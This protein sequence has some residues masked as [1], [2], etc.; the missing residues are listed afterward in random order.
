M[1]IQD[2]LKRIPNNTGAGYFTVPLKSLDK[3]LR[4]KH[5][6]VNDQKIISKLSID[7]NTGTFAS[8]ADLAKISIAEVNSLE[9]IELDNIDVRD[10]FILC[11]AIR[12][13]NYMDD[14]IIKFKCKQCEHEF[15]K[16]LDFSKM[17]ALAT[18]FE[19]KL[20]EAEIKTS[21]GDMKVT[22]GIPKQLD[23]IMLEM[24]YNRVAKTRDVTTAEKYIDYIIVCM[25]QAYF[26]ND[27]DQWEEVEDFIKMEYLDK[28]EFMQNIKANIEDI[29]KLFAEIGM[30]TNEFFYDIDCPKCKEKNKPFL[31]TSDFF[32]L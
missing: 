2:I 4:I 20:K 25:K 28:V 11:C 8:E 29:S 1:N 12:K 15:D 13:E 3:E 14:F 18:D 31:D 5:L 23:L 26:K 21:L 19:I 17:I 32:T 16:D 27:T 24:Y 30:I 22:I 10:Y 7:D 9:P 6:S